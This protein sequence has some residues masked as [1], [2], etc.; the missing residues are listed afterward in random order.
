MVFVYPL[1]LKIC[2]YTLPVDVL[3]CLPC[4]ESSKKW[5]VCEWSGIVYRGIPSMYFVYKLYNY[6]L[7]TNCVMVSPWHAFQYVEHLRAEITDRT[8]NKI[9]LGMEFCIL[10]K[11]LDSWLWIQS[12]ILI[13]TH[14]VLLLLL[15]MYSIIVNSQCMV[16]IYVVI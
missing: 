1:T 8:L 13:L 3:P 15:F 14:S 11:K 4:P 6:V 2:L 7:L 12:V 16:I 9:F 10:N 5:N